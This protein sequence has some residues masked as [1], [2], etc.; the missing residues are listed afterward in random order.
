MVPRFAAIA[1]SDN[2]YENIQHDDSNRAEP[3]LDQWVDRILERMRILHSTMHT[4]SR[5]TEGAE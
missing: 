5:F 3:S 4:L 2:H 1:N